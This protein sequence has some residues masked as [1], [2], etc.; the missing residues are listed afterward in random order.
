MKIFE[1][2]VK[3]VGE[4]Q[5]PVKDISGRLMMPVHETKF[6]L[7]SKHTEYPERDFDSGYTAEQISRLIEND[8]KGYS[9]LQV[10]TKPDGR[11]FYQVGK[12]E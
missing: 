8:E 6:L 3:L 12:V 4:T 10:V 11:S 1:I 7:S 9:G 2:T 5:I